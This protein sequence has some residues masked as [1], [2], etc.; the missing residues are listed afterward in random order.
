MTKIIHMHTKTLSKIKNYKNKVLFKNIKG[1]ILKPQKTVPWNYIKCKKYIKMKY[2]KLK[3]NKFK[4]NKKYRNIYNKK[5]DLKWQKHKTK[6]PKI[7]KL[8]WK[9]KMSKY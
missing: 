2:K 6:L 8:T 1:Y 3:M 5:N 7:I 4:M 9:Q